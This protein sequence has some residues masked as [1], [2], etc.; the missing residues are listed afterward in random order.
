VID[1]FDRRRT[2]NFQTI[3]RN[4]WWCCCRT[5]VYKTR[6]SRESYEYEFGNNRERILTV[7]ILVAR[8]C[9]VLSRFWIHDY[10]YIPV[11]SVGN[12]TTTSLFFAVDFHRKMHKPHATERGHNIYYYVTFER[13]TMTTTKNYITR[14][15]QHAQTDWVLD[16][17]TNSNDFS[18]L[19]VSPAILNTFSTI[20]PA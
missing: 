2:N 12:R 8:V 16:T 6:G 5:V 9:Q 3:L 7:F 10:I 19:H 1:Y 20:F 13:K 18:Q 14:N 15:T 4:N 17:G 11:A